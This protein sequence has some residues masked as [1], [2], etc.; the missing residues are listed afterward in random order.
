MYAAGGSNI[1]LRKDNE[2]C[3]EIKVLANAVGA[4]VCLMVVADGMGGHENGQLASRI[5]VEPFLAL[6]EQDI[7]DGFTTEQMQALFAKA[8][9][10]VF[11]RQEQL[12]DGIMGTTLTVA[13]V[14][15][16]TVWLGHVGDSRCYLYRD[17][18][19]QQLSIDHTY[20]AELLRL[21]KIET[22][23]EEKQRNVLM[24]AIGPEAE[25]EGQFLQQSLQEN[26]ILV[27]CTDGL[28]NA[29]SEEILTVALDNIKNT[30]VDDGQGESNPIQQTVDDLLQKALE[31]GARDNLTLI[32][33]RHLRNQI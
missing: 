24:R 14:Q 32:I 16:D 17:G 15:N 7:A 26:D 21:G 2:D 23:Q 6:T 10:A 9:Q 5:A 13:A 12:D 28:Y 33:Y 27:L 1:G 20:Y 30:A 22:A 3:Y 8:N 19:L 29:V 18:A 4:S 25:T 11:S 31:Q